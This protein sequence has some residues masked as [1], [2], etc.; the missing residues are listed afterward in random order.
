MPPHRGS[1]PGVEAEVP[2]P[3]PDFGGGLVFL[4]VEVDIGVRSLQHFEG[5]FL[6]LD[7]VS[8]EVLSVSGG[9]GAENPHENAAAQ[10]AKRVHDDMRHPPS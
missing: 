1:E 4:L 8:P 10:A 2:H 7:F 3:P 6:V 5:E 9:D